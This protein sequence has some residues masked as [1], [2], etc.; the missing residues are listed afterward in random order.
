MTPYVIE[1]RGEEVARC[2]VKALIECYPDE[3]FTIVR[4]GPV[5][6]ARPFTVEFR[7]GENVMIVDVVGEQ[8]QDAVLFLGCFTID[9]PE[10]RLMMLGEDFCREVADT[11]EKALA[12]VTAAR[13]KNESADS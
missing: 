4:N 11:A 6:P 13:E 7:I 2:V 1:I 10:P 9:Y 8:I 5:E 3:P 12:L